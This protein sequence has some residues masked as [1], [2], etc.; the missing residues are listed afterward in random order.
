MPEKVKVLVTG[1]GGPAGMGT[2]R[3]LMR[4]RWIGVVAADINHLAPGLYWAHEK[5]LLPPASDK[6]FLTEIISLCRR[7]K[8]DVLFPTVDE[9]MAIIAQN[10][11]KVGKAVT[12]LIGDTAGVE[13]CNDKLLTY[14][15]LMK[16]GIPVV[17]TRLIADLDSAMLASD[18]LEY[19]VALKPRASR[20]GRGLSICKDEAEFKEGYLSLVNR[21]PFTDAYVGVKEASEVILQEYLP[22]TEYDVIVQMDRR[23]RILA[24]VPMKAMRWDVREQQ[25]EIAT[26]HDKE[27]EDLAARTVR[28]LGLLCPV[29]VEMAQDRTGRMKILDVNPRVGGD[30]D[31]ATEA[32]CNIPAMHVKLALGRKV[33]PCDFDDG[34]TL[35]RYVGI[36][37]MRPEEMPRRRKR[38]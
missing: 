37:V 31:L 38:K 20:G 19:P 6:S 11:D 5:A 2:I 33:T 22:G 36:Q 18:V 9:E 7:L 35:V 3:S 10:H 25:R 12:C 21:L 16:A 8:V 29:D 30:V 28:A 14:V 1:A 17:E 24:C 27:V 15:V 13:T 32:G 4:E 26:E 34:L 23:D